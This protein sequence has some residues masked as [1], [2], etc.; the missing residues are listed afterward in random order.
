MRQR[1]T[2]RWP[3]DGARVPLAAGDRE[4]ALVSTAR[5]GRVHSDGH[6]LALART[7]SRRLLAACCAQHPGQPSTSLLPM[8]RN[9]W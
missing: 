2:Q 4:L 5:A 3:I 6:E 9:D 8:W 7:G 1:S